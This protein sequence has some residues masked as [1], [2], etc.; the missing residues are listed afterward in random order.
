MKISYNL[1]VL[2]FFL[3]LF[4]TKAQE[5]IFKRSGEQIKALVTEINVDNI[6]YKDWANQAGPI[7]TILKSQVSKIKYADGTEDIMD[8]TE[9][10]N[11]TASKPAVS[12]NTNKNVVTN[13][14]TN[15][16]AYQQKKSNKPA[17]VITQN[18][19][20]PQKSF[21]QKSQ[22]QEGDGKPLFLLLGINYF[23][24][25]VTNGQSGVGLSLGVGYKFTE[26]LGV[27]ASIEPNYIFPPKGLPTGYDAG[28]NIIGSAYPAVVYK[29]I[30][31]IYLYGGVGA[32]GS[33]N[34][35][36]PAKNLTTSLG[37]SGGVMLDITA[38]I[39]VKAGY[40]NI[41][42]GGNSTTSY[43]NIGVIKSLNW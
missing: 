1:T 14:N 38:L 23:L 36:L 25:P 35:S 27:M 11:V 40:N 2:F 17:P 13:S 7:Q 29:V 32:Y 21:S 3:M 18:T 39:G 22:K 19:T 41:I 30:P 34:S 5:I 43:V 37:Y 8:A 31:K 33:Y 15:V 26:S 42:D 20:K 12:T 4:N 24:Q 28:T 10:K 6:K 16:P 9:M